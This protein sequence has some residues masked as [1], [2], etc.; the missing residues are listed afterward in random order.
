MRLSEGLSKLLLAVLIFVSSAAA[1]AYEYP[2]VG[3]FNSDYQKV[4]DMIKAGRCDQ[5]ESELNALSESEGISSNIYK[6]ICFFEKTEYDRAFEVLE[7]MIAEQEYDEVLYVTRSMLDKGTAEPRLVKYRGL[8]LYNIGAFEKSVT[9]LEAYLAKYEDDDVR[10]SL[11]DIYIALKDFEKAETTL[12]AS[13]SRNGRYH[14]RKGRIALRTGKRNTALKNLRM[15]QPE[16]SRVYVS[17]K[18]LIGEICASSK[19]YICAEKEF[20]LAAEA[21]GSPDGGDEKLQKLADSKKRFSGFL[22]LGGQYDTNVTSIDENEIPDTS[23]V[24]SF[25]T[26]A[27]ADLKLNVYPSFADRL[28]FGTLHYFT[29]N[30][31][32]PSYDMSTHRVYVALRQGYDNFE[33]ILPKITAAVTYFDDEKY[34]NAFSAEASVRYK[35]DSWEFTVPLKVTRSNYM[36]DEDT[37]ET[38]RDGFKYESFFEVAKTCAQKYTTRLGVGYAVDRAEGDLKKKDDKLLRASFSARLT[39]KLTPVIG[40]R[41]ASYDYSDVDR[42]DT[43]Y[44]Y[45]LK[46]VYLLTPNIFLGGGI[47]HTRTDSNES[48]YDYTKTVSEVSVSYS[49]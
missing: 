41:Y 35:M 45:S 15:V 42:E 4:F 23:E 17:A 38:S 6:S 2:V 47:T 16:D 18:T 24:S 36:N 43:Y 31:E 33:L 28:E 44:S 40:F 11:V 30:D 19:R 27:A 1:S 22:S 7:R 26:F 34:S 29:W 20:K 5:M 39:P 46:A 49:F 12:E 10:F 3:E 21:E 9:D 8:A 14:Y 37:P 25:R 32:I 48:A 13:E